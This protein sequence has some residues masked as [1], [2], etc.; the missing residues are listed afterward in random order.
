MRARI[1]SLSHGQL[2]NT[3]SAA[4]SADDRIKKQWTRA[5]F[6]QPLFNL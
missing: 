3:I 6:G 4:A 5:V 2:E 1:L